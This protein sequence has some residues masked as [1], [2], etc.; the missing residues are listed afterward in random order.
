M[1][2]KSVLNSGSCSK[3]YPPQFK[4]ELDIFEKDCPNL[5]LFSQVFIAQMVCKILQCIL[6]VQLGS[7]Y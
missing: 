5:L 2:W 7:D 3:K 4:M 6:Y 1:F